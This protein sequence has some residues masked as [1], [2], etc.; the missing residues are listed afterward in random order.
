[1]IIYLGEILVGF[2]SVDE[3]WWYGRNASGREGIFPTSLAWKIDL[4]T[5]QV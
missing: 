4:N 2:Y 5:T 1:M 3:H